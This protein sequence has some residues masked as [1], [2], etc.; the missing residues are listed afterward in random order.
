VN[1]DLAQILDCVYNSADPRAYP[2]S[3][4][5]YMIVPTEEKGVFT[6]AKGNTLGAF[7][8]YFLCEGQQQA[9]SLGYSPLTMNLVLA[10]FEQI[11]RI[12]GAGSANV[13]PN[14]CNNPTFTAGDSPSSNQLAKTAP[15]P[16]ACDKQGPDQCT[17]GTAGALQSTPVSGSGNGGS[18]SNATGGGTTS[19]GVTGTTDGAATGDG[20]VPLYDEN[21]NAIEGSSTG[22]GAAA[23]ASPFAVKDEGW[24][25][26]QTAMLAAVVFLL[27]AVIAPP[28]MI[29]ILRSGA[30]KGGTK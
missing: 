7:M 2:L 23:V 28:A 27:L 4:Y 30:S 26:Q 20:S 5:S 8:S 15:Q 21:G 17:T 18:A 22:G 13:D 19:G 25:W 9:S 29:R 1:T 11:K 12:P 16:A 6:A 24:G 10:G 3:S 14:K